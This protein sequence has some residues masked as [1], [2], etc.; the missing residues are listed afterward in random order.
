MSRILAAALACILVVACT[1]TSQGQ[2]VQGT[3]PPQQNTIAS[4]LL[5]NQEVGNWL[6]GQAFRVHSNNNIHHVILQKD[7]WTYS[8][9]VVVQDQK[10]VI[11][12]PFGP[13][14]APGQVPADLQKRVADMASK[15]TSS[16]R[17]FLDNEGLILEGVFARPATVEQFRV[18]FDNFLADYRTTYPVWSD[19]LA[20]LQLPTAR[21]N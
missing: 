18:L 21:P 3:M 19:F 13:K 10:I 8:V 2:F 7:N 5:S 20:S 9:T 12:A 11:A 4:G 14:V 6:R 1:G 15:L 16:N 17:F